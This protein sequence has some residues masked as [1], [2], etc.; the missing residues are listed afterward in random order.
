M[1]MTSLIIV[2]VVVLVAI[3]TI[4][5]ILYRY[6]KC[7]SDELLVVYGK[8]GSHKEKVSERDAKG[9][10]VDREVEIKTA[11]VYHGGAA[12]VWPIIQGYEVMSMQPIQLNLV[13]KN[14][15]SAQ[16]IR[17]T[18]PTTVTVAISQEPLIMQNAANRLLGAD[19]DVKESLIS[20]IVYGQM[21][22]VIASMTIEELNSD[23]DKFL[24]QARDN[25]NTELNK[26]GLYLMNINISDIQ[27]AA[28]YIDNLGKKEETKARAQSQADIAEEEKKGAIQIAQ[29]TR[30]KEIA[31]AAATKEQET[32]V[33]ET[34]RE[35]EVAIAKT[36][37]EKETQ[38]AEQHKEQQIAVAEQ[39]KER[40]IG[41]ATAQT[42]EASKVAE[43][44]ALRAAKIA[45]Q[46]AYATAKE[47]EF[48]A[49]AE[50]AKAEAEAEKEVRMAVAAQNQ[51]AET[52][53]AQQEK[54]A[55]TAQY[56]S[57]ARQ[58]AA[59]AEKAA[60][61]AEQKATIEVSKAKG[62]AEK[63]KA[64]AE[65]VAGTSKVEAQMAVAKT[66]QERQVEVNEAKAKAEEA[67]LK[68]EVIIPAEKAK[69]KA[70]IEA[71]AVKSVAILEAEAEA[72]KILKAAEA[73][74]NATKMQLEAEAEGTKKKLLA[75]AEG[76]K[77]SLM[78]EAEQK[79]AMEMAPALAVEHMIKSGM[80]PEAIV[81][82][83]MTD[84]W[85]EVAEANAKVFEHIQLGNVTVYGDSNTAGQFMANMAKNLAPSL[86]IARNLPIADSLKQIITGKKP[87]ESP[88]NGDKFPPVK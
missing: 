32:I 24:A 85:K 73:K 16:N 67:K 17:V 30:E 14:A 11:K 76:K 33:A 66:E 86:E 53:K 46:Q 55:K 69:E 60:G 68:A 72:A 27:D 18:I 40:E 19:D 71:E 28:Q 51:E 88:A 52:V 64:E 3:I 48:T 34:N 13:L 80:H 77:A 2:G 9:N 6:R 31:I 35:K 50:A 75:E 39:R 70:K 38:L 5:G 58:K 25:I 45:E 87:E 41:V 7:K 83:A 1:E 49:K 84:R 20:D 15:L 44:E 65:R 82:Y 57:E 56:E 26:L 43:Q 54:E 74:A 47:A 22:L 61:V 29:T 12:F 79:Q 81:Q 4:I 23:R 62:E 8:T 36:T 21:R 63:A 59:E 37:K 10:L 78:A 42:E